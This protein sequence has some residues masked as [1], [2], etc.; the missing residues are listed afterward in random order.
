MRRIA[1]AVV[2]LCLLALLATVCGCG[3]SSPGADSVAKK[4]EPEPEPEP[5]GDATGTI[6]YF[7]GSV[8]SVCAL[9]VASGATTVLS[10]LDVTASFDVSHTVPAFFLY[11]DGGDVYHQSIDGE[12]PELVTVPLSITGLRPPRLSPDDT[13]VAFGPFIGDLD[14][15]A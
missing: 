2:V 7:D 5:V 1:E 14:L 11:D 13:Q 10:Q 12:T 4:P 6:Y 9:D 15:V 3:G 8:G